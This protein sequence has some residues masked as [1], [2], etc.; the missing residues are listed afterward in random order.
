M[1]WLVLTPQSSRAVTTQCLQ[2]A[3]KKGVVPVVEAMPMSDVNK[4]IE[5]INA[6]KANY[7]IVLV[8]E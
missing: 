7:R 5:R 4:A 8:N 6:G 2:F 3:A 1:L